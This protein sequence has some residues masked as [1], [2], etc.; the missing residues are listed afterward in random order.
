MTGF[1]SSWLSGG[2]AAVAMLASPAAAAP[3]CVNLQGITAQCLYFDA[4]QCRAQARRA[5]GSCAV[6]PAELTLPAGGSYPYCLTGPGYTSCK[7]ADRG[8][9]EAEAGR[10]R[11]TCVES[12]AAGAASA[13]PDPYRDLYVTGR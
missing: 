8:S 10:Q 6:N 13:P 3:Y 5:G 11:A 7:F 2:I 12:F 1:M 4:N 9:C